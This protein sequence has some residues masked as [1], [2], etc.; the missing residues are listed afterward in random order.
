MVGIEEKEGIPNSTI[1]FCIKNLV[2]LGLIECGNKLSKGKPV[3]LTR[4]GQLL[5]EVLGDGKMALVPMPL[6]GL[7]G[8]MKR[9]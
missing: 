1:R 4:K 8:S 5:L 7:D 2:N 9:I 3:R 6:K